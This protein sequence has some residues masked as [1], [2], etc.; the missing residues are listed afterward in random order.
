MVKGMN[1]GLRGGNGE[2]GKRKSRN[3]RVIFDVWCV[4]AEKGD[5]Q[6][7]DHKHFE[8]KLGKLGP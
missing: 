8:G 5:E 6:M 2:T 1:S 7:I 3:G 4:K